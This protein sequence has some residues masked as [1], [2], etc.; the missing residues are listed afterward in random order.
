MKKQFAVVKLIRQT[1][2][3]EADSITEAR[4]AAQNSLLIDHRILSWSFEPVY[5]QVKPL[6]QNQDAAEVQ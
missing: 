5:E 3:V 2:I 1:T 4:E 6:K